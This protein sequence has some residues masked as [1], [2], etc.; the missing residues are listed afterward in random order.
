MREGKLKEGAKI[1]RAI[2]RLQQKHPRVQRFYQVQWVAQPQG[3][4][5]KWIRQDQKR[6]ADEDL[7]GCYVL[8]TDQGS[9]SAEQIWNL[10]M[11]L[12]EAEDGFRSLKGDLG[13]RPNYHQIERRVEGHIWITILAY[14]LLCWIQETLREAGDVRRWGT[15]RRVLQTHCYTTIVV[16]T[17][18]GKTHR[19]R[20]AG[21]PEE[22]QK[23][24]Y[25]KLKLNWKELP[26]TK[27]E[28]EA[29]AIL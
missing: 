3:N 19:L 11:T 4:E 6:Q 27:L 1:D 18:R 22:L 5:L 20:R 16:P 8:R 2:G 10:Y 7:L 21:E 29:G 26:Q 14:H 23:A 12:S 13:L 17:K 24:I 15:L 28:V 9:E 25:E